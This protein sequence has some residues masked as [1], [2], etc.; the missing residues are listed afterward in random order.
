MYLLPYRGEEKVTFI[1]INK[2][3]YLE[4]YKW[5]VKIA[6]YTQ[7]SGKWAW[8]LEAAGQEYPLHLAE[9][10]IRIRTGVDP[11]HLAGALEELDDG[12]RV[13]VVGGDALLEALHV[14]VRPPGATLSPSQA[15]LDAHILGAVEEEHELHV[16]LLGHLAIPAVQ[17]I[18]IPG[19]A[20]DEEPGLARR[21][22]GVLQQRARDLHG[23]NLAIADVILDQGAELGALAGTLLAQQI[24]GRE[25]GELEAVHDLGALGALSGSWTAQNED[26]LWLLHA[27]AGDFVRW[28]LWIRLAGLAGMS[29]LQLLRQR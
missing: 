5:R 16:H 24:P 6:H 26:N 25:M 27:H 1:T 9:N 19:E 11:F 7:R 4:E 20:V 13:V 15:P 28:L 18:L 21:L 12:Q 3:I 10:R 17:I 23:H 29:Q 8:N 14:V 22:H 2:R